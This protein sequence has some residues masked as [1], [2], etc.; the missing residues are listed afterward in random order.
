MLNFPIFLLTYL[1]LTYIVSYTSNEL[2]QE[3]NMTREIIKTQNLHKVYDQNSERPYEALKGISF[4]V[5]GRHYGRLRFREN[6]VIKHS[7]N[8]G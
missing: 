3:D 5:D 2:I 4:T 1:H 7:S 8:V 6:N